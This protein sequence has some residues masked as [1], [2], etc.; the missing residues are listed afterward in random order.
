MHLP[1]IRLMNGIKGILLASLLRDA[2]SDSNL[3]YNS[4]HTQFTDDDG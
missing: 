1:M 4:R 2:M 3:A